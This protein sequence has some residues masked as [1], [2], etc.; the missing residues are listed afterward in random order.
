MP[1]PWEKERRDRIFIS[2]RRDDTSG[3]AGRLEDSLAVYF[4]ASRV[5]RDI[6]GIEY[7]SDFERAIDDKVSESGAV[8]VLIGDKWLEARDAEGNRRLDDPND[9]VTRE[10]ASALNSECT[11]VPVLVGD[12]VVPQPEQLPEAIRALSKRNALTVT[13]ERWQFDIDRLAKVLAIDIPGTVIQR[14][15]N[16]LRLGA[17]TTLAIAGLLAVLWFT[18]VLLAWNEGDVGLRASGYSPLQSAIPQIGVLLAGTFALLAAPFME[19]PR[20]PIALA[21]TAV[22]Y[23]IPLALFVHYALVN[24]EQPDFSLIVNFTGS[25]IAIVLTLALVGLAGFRER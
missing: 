6:T 5:F 19:A 2:Y 12:A 22:A 13:D 7:G 15:L 4:G 24:V 23:F 25:V 10:I 20:R 9:Y 21:A 3:F 17:V 1:W 18:P 11:V 8:I 16:L 14:R